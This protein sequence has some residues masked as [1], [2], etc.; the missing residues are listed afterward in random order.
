MNKKEIIREIKFRKKEISRQKNEIKKLEIK[1]KNKTF[2]GNCE[3]CSK[4][5]SNLKSLRNHERGHKEWKERAKLIRDNL[6]IEREKA[7]K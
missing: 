3:F 6:V 5:F 2:F 1:L 4:G 7:L